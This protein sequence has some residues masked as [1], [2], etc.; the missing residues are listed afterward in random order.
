MFV[1]GSGAGQE[2]KRVD[3]A[4]YRGIVV[5]NNDPAKL[6]RVKIYIPELTNQ[7][8]DEWFEKFENINIKAPGTN[9]TD[10]W[11]DVKMF[12]EISKMI[13]WAEQCTPLM[14]E[15]GSF[16]Y[17]KDGEISTIS[18]C[19]YP[20]GFQ[21][22][23]TV[24]PSLSAGSFSPAFLYE[25]SG[26]ALGDAFSNPLGNFTVKCNPYSFAYR[27]SKHVNKCKGLFGIPNVGSKVWVF[28]AEGDLNFPVYFGGMNDYRELSLINNNDNAEKLSFEYP[29]T[30]ES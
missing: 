20:E 1:R 30:F 7:P 6:N 21:I 26:T 23:D 29:S 10:N 13:S 12:E 19:N 5:K 22:N 17:Y 8:F 16:R 11:Q 14:G 15:M 27:P 28:H 9:N 4:F 2:Y 18:D 24:S 3:N 25:N